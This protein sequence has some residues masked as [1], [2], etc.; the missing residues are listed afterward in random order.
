MILLLL[1]SCLLLF[2]PHISPSLAAIHT[3]LEVLIF[4]GLHVEP[5][6]GDSGDKL[7]LLEFEK[8][9]GLACT[10]QPKGHHPHLYPRTDVDPVVLECTV[11]T[12]SYTNTHDKT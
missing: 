12:H 3:Y 11:Y 10:V 7:I 6:G 4:D 2:L 8:D 9:G 1:F 5:D